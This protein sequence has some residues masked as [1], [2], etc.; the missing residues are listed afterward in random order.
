[1]LLLF[2]RR[3]IPAIYHPFTILIWLGTANELVSLYMI[4]HV[5]GNMFNSNIYVLLEYLL[6]LWQF[7]RWNSWRL[8]I[9]VLLFLIGVLVWIVD[10]IIVHSL[11]TNNSLFR[12]IYS[13]I[14]MLLSIKQ[15]SKIITGETHHLLKNTQFLICMA[16]ILYYT[17]KAYFES[18]NLFDV[19][20]SDQFFYWL[21]LVLNI[22]NLIVNIIYSYAILWIKKKIPLALL[23]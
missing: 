4:L 3:F 22:L 2:R 6:L 12:M 11:T 17:F 7:K 23:Y 10:N 21:W 14:I 9:P 8:V 1:M 16:F 15:I 20:I 5:N 19:G 18:F 13:A